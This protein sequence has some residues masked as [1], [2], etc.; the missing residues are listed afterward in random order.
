MEKNIM[1]KV[2]ASGEFF[3]SKMETE[4]VLN[5]FNFQIDKC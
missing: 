5:S 1:G 4:F 3:F 2:V